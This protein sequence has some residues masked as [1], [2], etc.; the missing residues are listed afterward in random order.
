MRGGAGAGAGAAAR[1]A[2]FARGPR[3]RLRLRVADALA[4]PLTGHRCK[5]LGVL[6][7][8]EPLQ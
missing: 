4:G 3:L 7:A 2:A 6:P 5:C 8:F 1:T